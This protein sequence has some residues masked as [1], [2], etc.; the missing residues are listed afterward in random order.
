MSTNLFQELRHIVNFVINYQPHIVFIVVLLDLCVSI[1][2]SIR[3]LVWIFLPMIWFELLIFLIC[4]Q[5]IISFAFVAIHSQCVWTELLENLK[6]LK[7]I[8]WLELLVLITM[9][10]E[11]GLTFHKWTFNSN[12]NS[13]D[14]NFEKPS[15]WEF[16]SFQNILKCMENIINELDNLHK[17]LL[18]IKSSSLSS[19]IFSVA[20][21]ISLL[22]AIFQTF[23]DAALN[24]IYV[25]QTHCFHYA[26][27]SLE[28]ARNLKK[29]NG[30]TRM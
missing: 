13:F 15:Q 4:I 26:L 16:I 28:F 20:R 18:W 21:K 12:S 1:F 14:F 11:N 19:F 5:S 24:T 30:P 8:W 25:C 17:I 9:T 23:R 22:H 2:L 6:R 27:K 29:I 10:A 3:H 7:K